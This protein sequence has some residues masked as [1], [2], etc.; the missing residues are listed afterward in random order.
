[1]GGGGRGR[2][3]NYDADPLTGATHTI[4]KYSKQHAMTTI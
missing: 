3:D 2:L 4:D 1:M